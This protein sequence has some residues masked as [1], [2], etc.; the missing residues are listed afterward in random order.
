MFGILRIIGFAILIVTMR[1]AGGG[2]PYSAV[3][4]LRRVG[5]TVKT[6]PYEYVWDLAGV[7]LYD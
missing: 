5:G 1:S 2:A 4:L 6:V 3:I 7:H